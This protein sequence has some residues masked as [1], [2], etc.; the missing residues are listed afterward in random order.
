M[1]YPDFFDAV[2]RIALRDPLAAFLGAVDDGVIEYGYLDAVKL[3]GHSCPTVASAYWLTRQALCA[4]YGEA[5]AERGGVRVA[6]RENRATGVAGVIA[7]VVG[8]LTGAAGDGGFKGLGGRFDRRDLLAFEADQPLDLRF[9]RVDT[10]AAVEAAVALRQVPADPA[11]APLM[12]RCVAGTASAEEAREFRAL[13]QDRVRRV[14]LE[15]GDDPE[16]FII[17]PAS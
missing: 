4:L 7:N 2:P 5:L 10:G 6:L 17:R 9:T 16:V 11:M 12:Q 15:H 8:L 14:L 1:H 3:A 13:W